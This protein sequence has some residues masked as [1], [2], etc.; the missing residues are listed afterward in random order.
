MHAPLSSQSL[1]Y[2]LLCLCLD[3]LFFF[4]LFQTLPSF[5]CVIAPPKRCGPFLV[6]QCFCFQKNYKILFFLRLVSPFLFKDTRILPFNTHHHVHT[7]TY[8]PTI[9]I[10]VYIIS[11]HPDSAFDVKYAT[12]QLMSLPAHSLFEGNQILHVFIF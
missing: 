2:P 8:K 3:V 6:V 7:Q 5:W 1:L 4:F 9:N 11:S 12:L 10:S